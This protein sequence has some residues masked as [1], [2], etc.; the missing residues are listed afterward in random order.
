VLAIAEHLAGLCAG[1]EGLRLRPDVPS[2]SDASPT[3]L[4][5]PLA[6]EA[7][8]EAADTLAAVAAWAREALDTEHVPAFWR[9][10]AHQPRLLQATW[11]KDRLVLGGGE[12]DAA[13]KAC[14]ALAVAM[15]K[16]SP[17]WITY[18]AQLVRRTAGLDNAAIVELT[19]A[20]MHYVSYNTIAHGMRL[21]PA[22]ANMTAAQF[23][24]E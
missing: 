17:Y 20:V 15:F 19:G 5:P 21:E 10:L 24:S 4:V 8:G 1:A 23:R 22:Y 9:A 2:A 7:A 14:V 12:L 3:E 13:A 6:P 18:L 11:A 16:E